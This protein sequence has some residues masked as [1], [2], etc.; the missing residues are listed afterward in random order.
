MTLRERSDR[1]MLDAALVYG[2]PYQTPEGATIITVSAWRDDEVTPVG[3][4]VVHGGEVIWKAAEDRVALL[5][6]R[7]NLIAAAVGT[8]TGLVAAAFATGALL[9]RPPWPD[10]RA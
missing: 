8:I 3:I 2:V 6:A 4:F 5:Q 10:I 9:R 7:T 1:K